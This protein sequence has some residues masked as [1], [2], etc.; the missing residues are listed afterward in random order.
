[1][2]APIFLS[3]ESNIT[4]VGCDIM[5]AA[6][7]RNCEAIMATSGVYAFPFVAE[8]GIRTVPADCHDHAAILDVLDAQGLRDRVA[9]VYAPLDLHCETAA[10]VAAAL[11]LPGNSR[12]A[13]ARAM[14]KTGTR[15]FLQSLGLDDV[16]FA[17]ASCVEA[18]VESARTIGFPVILKPKR[19]AGAVGV[20]LCLDVDEVA[21]HAALILATPN[22]LSVDAS[23][24][25]IEAVVEGRQFDAHVFNGAVVAVSEVLFDGAPFFRARGFDCPAILP[26][27]SAAAIG[28]HVE[29]IVD[30][31]GMR[32]G[33]L[34]VE[35]RLMGSGQVRLIE[36][37]PRLAGGKLLGLVQRSTGIDLIGAT[38]DA[39]LGREPRAPILAR[40]GPRGAA[41]I[42]YIMRSG[43]GRRLNRIDLPSVRFPQVVGFSLDGPDG[44]PTNDY[45]D[46]MG[47]IIT[48]ASTAEASAG[49]AEQALRYCCADQ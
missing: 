34:D 9:G 11:G 15:A 12:A 26:A 5:L 31:L 38:V 36:V 16:G 47:H 39:C 20:R 48:A 46:R 2:S 4:G 23:G 45:R 28:S 37:N 10:A 33:P 8:H 41:S 35:V 44:T 29:E 25:V 3:I 40:T 22:S 17:F 13:T 14:D 32:W 43:A 7:A 21:G 42:R 24:I 18:A 30:A 1:M 49:T 19:A 6:R 27:E